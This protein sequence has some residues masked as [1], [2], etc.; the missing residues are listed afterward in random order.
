MQVMGLVGRALIAVALVGVMATAPAAAESPTT[1]PLESLDARPIAFDVTVEPGMGL[2]GSIDISGEEVRGGTLQLT[3]DA[4][5]VFL[6][7]V[8]IAGAERVSRGLNH[9]SGSWFC[10]QA[11]SCGSEVR[12]RIDPLVPLAAD[13]DIRVR[14]EAVALDEQIPD[15]ANVSIEPLPATSVD[16]ANIVVESMQIEL[17]GEFSHGAVTYAWDFPAPDGTWELMVLDDRG[18]DPGAPR[19]LGAV[20]SA[21]TTPHDAVAWSQDPCPDDRCAGRAVDSFAPAGPS[22]FTIALILWSPDPIGLDDVD[23]T[24]TQSP[25]ATASGT[26][27]LDSSTP[28]V[29]VPVFIGTDGPQD[30]DVYAYV[31]VDHVVGDLFEP[32]NVAL[33]HPGPS[34]YW[35]SEQAT[36]DERR[37]DGLA[38]YELAIASRPAYR[39]DAT[40]TVNWTIVAVP[41]PYEEVPIASEIEIRTGEP[42]RVTFAEGER[43]DPARP[44]ESGWWGWVWRISLSAVALAAAGAAAA[45]IW[46]RGLRVHRPAE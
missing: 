29:L 8:G 43:G 24:I 20:G 39:G 22:P 23:L 30:L 21:R 6:V 28:D 2:E 27:T 10:A 25:T 12:Y 18:L 15:A 14:V 5:D 46:R 31:E 26:F 11:S 4:D 17:V 3:V 40:M 7:Q 35:R 37:P 16:P 33:D 38:S 32:V 1:I 42:G 13:T 44:L 45:V 41:T 9:V 36:M 34:R 19:P